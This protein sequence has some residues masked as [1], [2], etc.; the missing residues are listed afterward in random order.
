[1]GHVTI[2]KKHTKEIVPLR[3]DQSQIITVRSIATNAELVFG[4]RVCHNCVAVACPQLRVGVGVGVGIVSSEHVDG[5]TETR[6]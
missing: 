6:A 1:M 3:S 4:L 2:H 5:H